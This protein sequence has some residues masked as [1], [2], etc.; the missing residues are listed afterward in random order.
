MSTTL[1]VRVSIQKQLSSVMLHP[2]QSLGV[3]VVVHIQVLPTLT[4]PLQS[5]G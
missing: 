2:E 1:G 5:F 3:T 4:H